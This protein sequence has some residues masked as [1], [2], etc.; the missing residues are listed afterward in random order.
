MA[1]AHKPPNAPVAAPPVRTLQERT[2]VRVKYADHGPGEVTQ[3]TKPR[4]ELAAKDGK[5]EL[6]TLGVLVHGKYLVP[7]ANIY[8]VEFGE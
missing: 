3:P 6:M 2:I 1:A 5:L 8:W 7:W 4:R